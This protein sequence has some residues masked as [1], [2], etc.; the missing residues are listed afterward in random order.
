MRPIPIDF[1]LAPDAS[2]A[3]KIKMVLSQEAAG[4]YR[5]AGTWAELMAQAE[6]VY[7]LPPKSNDWS[8]KLIK[9][10]SHD[11]NAFWCSSFEV[12]PKET[13]SEVDSALNRLLEAAGPNYDLNTLLEKTPAGTR[14][15]RRLSDITNLVKTLDVMPEPINTM[16]CLLANRNPPL[17]PIRVYYIHNSMDLNPWQMAVLERLERDTSG[18]DHQ[19]QSLLETSLSPPET[20]SLTLNTVRTLYDHDSEPPAQ[21]QGLR[22][23]A[24]RDSLEEAEIVAGL[25]QKA[26]ENGIRFNEIGLLLPDDP[27]GLM[28]VENMFNKCGLPL[29]GFHRSTGERD[30]GCETIR[31]FLLC[32]RKPAPIMAIAAL[33]TSPLMPWSFGEGY[34]L[35]QTVMA[36]DVLLKSTKISSAARKVMDIL[37]QSPANPKD[38]RGFLIEFVSLLSN[39]EGFHE[40]RQRAQDKAEELKAALDG[41]DGIN[42][43]N[44][45]YLV[46]PESLNV[47]KPVN[48][49][50][51]AIPVF[52]EGSLPWCDVR[53]LFVLGFNEGHYPAGAGASAVFTEAEWELLADTGFPVLTNDLIRKRQRTLFAKQ[54]SAATEELTLSFSCRDACGQTLE[55]S[56][57]LVFLERSLGVES[58]DLV[59]DLDRP[60]DIRKI[61]DLPL[62]ETASPTPPRDL[63]AHDIELKVD[64]LEAFSREDTALAPLSPSAAETLMVSPFA[65]ILRKLDCKPRIWT[66]DDFDVLK[67][68]TLAHSVFEELFQSDKPLPLENQI[69][70]RVSKILHEK[71]LQIA[72]FLRSPDWRVERYKLEAEIIEAAIHWKKL[73]RSCGAEVLS[74]EQWLRGQHGAIPLHGQSDLLVQ[75]PSGKLLVVDYKKS[76]SAKRR[77]RM[78]KGFDLQA[79]LYRTMI[80]TGG[81]PGFEFSADDIGI[82]YYLLNDTTALADGPIASDGSVP[83]WE[84][85]D[86]DISGQAMQHLDQ[87]LAQIR[88]GIVRLNSAEDEDWWL[89]NASLP[90]YALDDSPLLRLFMRGKDAS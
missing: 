86:S 76:S 74:A 42:W 5:M 78:R 43:N 50:Q 36:G 19:L 51:K 85:L 1:L 11:Q 72:P 34:D 47:P 60:D 65:W 18:L 61:Q 6:F 79:H 22:V 69:S 33:L 55:P 2:S 53:H 57:S 45:L 54:L 10:A 88:K 77:E 41:M 83:G 15:R 16:A 70:P 4:L 66:V 59:L 38:L 29:S 67:A 56:S 52:H 26:I 63:I 40:H 82:V 48:Y 8:G 44:L 30:L 9:A 62:A 25:I 89:D 35:A 49:W 21:I 37:D 46:T 64:L 90:V 7:M 87:R 39:Q 3:R 13:I 28:A 14:L 12:A 23:L 84:V 24:T 17:R 71:I 20:G 32:M 80:R 81:F 68:G 31:G 73:L 58:N 27:L 75:L